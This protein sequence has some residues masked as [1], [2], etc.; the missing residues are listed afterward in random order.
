MNPCTKVD[1]T[2]EVADTGREVA[3]QP[4]TGI[5]SQNPSRVSSTTAFMLHV[6]S[7][8]PDMACPKL[9]IERVVTCPSNCDI[10]EFKYPFPIGCG[11]QYLLPAGTY[12]INV[13][14]QSAYP[15]QAGETVNLSFMVEPVS[16]S[17]AAIYSG[18]RK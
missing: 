8:N 17:F 5:Q 12:D 7:D 16:D 3:G 13:C 14:N 1:V 2:L 18:A 4:M 11:T 15:L 6:I 10:R 9:N